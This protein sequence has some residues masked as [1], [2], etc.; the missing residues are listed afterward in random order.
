MH[1]NVPRLPYSQ[2]NSSPI[3]ESTQEV[4]SRVLNA[5]LLQQRRLGNSKLNHLMTTAELRQHCPLDEPC[6]LMLEK[7]A[8]RFQLS[9]R[10]IARVKKVART[11]ADLAGAQ[12]IEASHLAESLQ[13]RLR[14]QLEA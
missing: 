9:G 2:L 7:A 3:T 6:D 8:N 12:N 1:V 4:Q 5:R 14:D 11:I 10:A 13:Y